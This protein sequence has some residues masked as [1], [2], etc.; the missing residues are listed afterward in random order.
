[1]PFS[2]SPRTSKWL[3][4]DVIS[5]ILYGALLKIFLNRLRT[6]KSVRCLV[7][8]MGCN[9]QR[10]KY[11]ELPNA[12]SIR[13][14]RICPTR[15]AGVKTVECSITTVDLESHGLEYEALSYTW[16][17]A[18][19]EDEITLCEQNM[20]DSEEQDLEIIVDQTRVSLQLNL[21]HALEQFRSMGF[22]G[23]LWIDAICID[24]QNDKEKTS[25]VKLMRQIYSKAQKVLVWLGKD[26]SY[27]GGDVASSIYQL[28]ELGATNTGPSSAMNRGAS[29]LG[30]RLPDLSNAEMLQPFGLGDWPNEKWLSLGLFLSR[31][32]F[33]R[34]WCMQE[35]LLVVDPW[36]VLVY[37][38]DIILSW[39]RLNA[40]SA[41]LTNTDLGRSLSILV[42]EKANRLSLRRPQIG[43][44]MTSI[45]L[46][47]A[48]LD[49]SY[50]P[51]WEFIE[52]LTG[53][54][55]SKLTTARLLILLC[56]STRS[57]ETTDP[58]D[59]IFAMLGVLE[60]L[61]IARGLPAPRII[62]NYSKT[63][64]QVYLE[65]ATEILEGMKSLDL[66]NLV[67][68]PTL[69][70][71]PDMPS[72]VLD[73]SAPAA[74]PILLRGALNAHTHF[75][76]LTIAL[77]DSG[78]LK[79]QDTRLHLQG[80]RLGIISHLGDLLNELAEFGIFENCLE[81]LLNMPERYSTGQN[82]LEVFWRTTI[83]YSK[84]TTSDGD[85]P[86]SASSY[87][88]SEFK[89]WLIYVL[90]RRRILV[91]DLGDDPSGLSKYD[92]LLDCVNYLS[93]SGAALVFPSRKHIE[94]VMK[95]CQVTKIAPEVSMANLRKTVSLERYASLLWELYTARRVFLTSEKQLGLGHGSALPGDEVWILQGARTPFVLRRNGNLGDDTFQLIGEAYVHGFMHGEAVTSAISLKPICIV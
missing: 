84:E 76:A 32:W 17:E 89:D 44:E 30:G 80:F 91:F 8:A 46:L 61:S 45:V 90:I 7:K 55:G 21:Y 14:L 71:V 68:D 53:Q 19:D 64:Q 3:S 70:K 16:G 23:Y 49:S 6:W 29:Q 22:H 26:L 67:C 72:W 37:F 63:V 50:I 75:E 58:R 15:S 74:G 20:T 28:S 34:L 82:R 25:Q 39:P 1:M 4:P 83:C 86:Q 95:D 38:G 88:A 18:R 85:G 94:Q 52:L 81:V 12:H 35:V 2:E 9:I 33:R 31:R 79:I 41:F 57:W 47:G 36:L 92:D 5:C 78:S 10:Y 27:D 48:L 87:L 65:T 60:R 43:H 11:D 69:R 93:K 77:N 51:D 54:P 62:P 13:L 40:A 73:F 56:W 59:K 42:S 24:Q 66:L